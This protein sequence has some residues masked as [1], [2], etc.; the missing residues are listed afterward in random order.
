MRTVD[1]IEEKDKSMPTPEIEFG[2]GGK[3]GDPPPTPLTHRPFSCGI[4]L[5]IQ[6]HN[7][8]PS[9]HTSS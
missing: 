2:D 1:W 8:R 6:G 7:R 3:G 9:K 4:S 5:Y